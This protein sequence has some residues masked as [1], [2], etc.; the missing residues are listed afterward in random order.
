MIEIAP[1]WTRCA[2]V[3][4][5]LLTLVACGGGDTPTPDAA[6][7][8]AA[9]AADDPAAVLALGE[10]KYQQ[11]CVSCHQT[12]GLGS[13][14]IFPP[15]V[16]SD[17]LKGRPEIPIAI[18]LHGLQGPVVVKGETY[19]SAMQPWGMLP[20]ADIA[21]VVSYV[22][23]AFGGGASPVTPAQVAEIRAAE[24]GRVAWTIEELRA[25]YPQ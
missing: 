12:T 20:D 17:Y 23:N 19:D 7:P 22:R 11:V 25:K 21:A 15:L 5:A 2:V 1:R 10:Q 18:V 24:G 14:G 3:G 9:A 8:T 4:A 6:K 16:D 13:P